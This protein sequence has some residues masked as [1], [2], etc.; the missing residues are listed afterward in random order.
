MKSSNN[1][2]QLFKSIH[3]SSTIILVGFMGSG[4]TTFGKELAVKFNYRFIDTDREIEDLVGMSINEI[5][6]KKGEAYFR[7]IERQLIE[8]I[9]VKD[10]VIATGG[11]M[12]CFYDNMDY[13]NRI[14]V[15]I[16]LRYTVGQLFERLK[17]EDNSRPLLKNKSNEQLFEYIEA[18]L[19]KRESFYLKAQT[20]F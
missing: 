7:T 19:S 12:P 8:Q 15:T 10:T 16:Y 3:K 13:L 1:F 2:D 9:K 17:E 5:F 4:K 18:L 14:G 11:G 6:E 20:I